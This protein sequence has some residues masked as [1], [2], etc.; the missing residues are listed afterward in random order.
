MQNT[1]QYRI[2]RVR[3]AT[4][5]WAA[6]AVVRAPAT[7]GSVAASTRYEQYKSRVPVRMYVQPLAEVS[8]RTRLCILCRAYYAYLI[9]PMHSQGRGTLQHSSAWRGC[10]AAWHRWEVAQPTTP[11]MSRPAN[12]EG[13]PGP[14]WSWYTLVRPFTSARDCTSHIHY[15]LHCAY[16]ST[17]AQC[18]CCV[19]RYCQMQKKEFVCVWAFYISY[20][21]CD[22]R[23]LDLNLGKS[24]CA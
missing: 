9:L 16:G 8:E 22:T 11:G 12:A 15:D 7:R 19:V 6:I 18:I 5:C 14:T 10:C 23:M 17:M 4:P 24:K 21:T 13:Y 3:Q 2:L 20:I 1:K